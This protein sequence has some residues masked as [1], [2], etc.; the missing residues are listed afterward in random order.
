MSSGQFHAYIH[1]VSLQN[2]P[3]SLLWVCKFWRAVAFSTPPLWNSIDLSFS[4]LPGMN[5]WLNISP[6]VPFHL[7]IAPDCI[8]IGSDLY[9][10]F[11]CK[12]LQLFSSL[13]RMWKSLSI[14]LNPRIAREL[15]LLL[16]QPGNE[17]IPLQE[18]QLKFID[19]FSGKDEDTIPGIISAIQALPLLTRLDWKSIKLKG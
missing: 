2:P 18:L 11:P 8:M 19:E 12:I 6:K 7:R 10:A 1:N 14:L 16:Q 15:L 17:G 9:P 13:S 3:F 4:S 5:A